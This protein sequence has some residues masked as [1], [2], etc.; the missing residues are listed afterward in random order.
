V[1]TVEGDLAASGTC[2][3]I[4]ASNVTIEGTGHAIVG[5]GTGSGVE[6]ARDG[7][8]NVTV[9]N[10]TV[11]DVAT[12]VALT[13][14]DGVDATDVG[15]TD[16]TVGVRLNG[17]A[18]VVAQSVVVR[19]VADRG[20]V[21]GNASDVGIANTSV[22]DADGAAVGFLFD[23]APSVF[24][25]NLSVDGPETAAAVGDGSASGSIDGLTVRNVTTRARASVDASGLTILRLN[26]P[27][28]TL[29]FIPNRSGLG[30]VPTVA[31]PATAV[32]T[33]AEFTLTAEGAGGPGQ[34]T[35]AGYFQR[36]SV[37]RS[38]VELSRYDAGNAT[39]TPTGRT[40][41]FSA[42]NA[43]TGLAI[44]DVNRSGTY[45]FFETGTS[46]ASC[47]VIEQAGTYTLTGNLTATGSTGPCLAV[48]ASNVTVDADGVRLDAG[49][50]VGV[51][52][53]RD[54][55]ANVTVRGLTVRNASTGVDLN[56]TADPAVR[57]LTVTGG[58]GGTGL[59]LTGSTDATVRSSSVGNANGT[60]LA[61][62]SATGLDVADVTVESTVGVAA[63]APTGR[64]SQPATRAAC[65][66]R[67]STPRRGRSR[68]PRTGPDSAQSPPGRRRS[69]TGRSRR[70]WAGTT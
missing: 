27:E 32:G 40:V 2:L 30:P 26:A 14:T 39:W 56:G 45:G 28:G 41:R 60:G 33:I 58:Q 38:T 23:G 18:D 24:T 13:G 12:G 3:S 5:D 25:S 35:V 7:L 37:D 10:L 21:V 42:V 20:V 59:N 43:T 34:S 19:R 16:A 48:N 53:V 61:L 63:D 68:S 31:S 67:R 17:S 11:R 8:A 64:S 22:V 65:R 46:V 4:N 49:G 50:G 69:T 55:L 9:R 47:T 6:T 51:G 54:G 66:S 1:Y 15:V 70:P 62:G 44:V 52:V 57:N 29:A 36:A